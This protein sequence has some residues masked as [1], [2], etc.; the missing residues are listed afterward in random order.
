MLTPAM[1][2]WAGW[3]ASATAWEI[4]HRQCVRRVPHR[5]LV[6]GVRGKSTAVRLL[7]TGLRAGGVQTMGRVTGD[8]PL[9]ILPDGSEAAVARLGPANIREMRRSARRVAALN[10][11]ALCFENMAIRPELARAV[12]TKCVEPTTILFT[13]DGLDHGEVYPENNEERAAL[14]ADTFPKNSRVVLCESD[15]NIYLIDALTERGLAFSIPEILDEVLLHPH[16]RA[17]AGAVI[18]LL[19]QSDL[20][21]NKK[22]Q[23]AAITQRAEELQRIRTAVHEGRRLIDLLS[24]N[25]PDSVRDLIHSL[26]NRGLLPRTFSIIFAHRRDRPERLKSFVPI[27]QKYDSCVVGDALPARFVSRNKLRTEKNIKA[28]ISSLPEKPILLVGNTS[29]QGSEIRQQYFAAP[30][31]DLW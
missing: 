17:L 8:Q 4:Y 22:K 10:C 5:F 29:G 24:I 3:T 30:N 25:D 21:K 14:F 11:E 9:L 15:R 20:L 19:E 12:A 7:H 6:W 18:T 23:I 2:A 31:I 27:L 13:F 16:M 1:F 28:A 26:K